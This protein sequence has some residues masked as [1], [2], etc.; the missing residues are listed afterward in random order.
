MNH[1]R[2]SLRRWHRQQKQ[3]ICFVNCWHNK[4]AYF[5][6]PAVWVQSSR[7][8]YKALWKGSTRFNLQHSQISSG[9]DHRW[10]LQVDL[11]QGFDSL[12]KQCSINN[13]IVLM[14]CFIIKYLSLVDLLTTRLIGR[15]VSVAK[16]TS[17]KNSENH[18]SRASWWQF[19]F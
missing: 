2:A 15:S 14:T 11:R 3:N 10:S 19:K 7:S 6:S 9:K 16:L 13:S 8:L 4:Q 18:F 5:E 1:V 12:W 17:S